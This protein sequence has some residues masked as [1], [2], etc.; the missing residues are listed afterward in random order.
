[1]LSDAALLV[2]ERLSEPQAYLSILGTLAGGFHAWSDIARLS[3]V[4]EGNLGYYLQ[5][6]QELEMVERRDPVLAP[7]GN[8]RGRYHI[9]DAFLRFHFRFIVPYRSSIERGETARVVKI[10]SE[11]LRAFIG[12]YVYEELCREWTL[13]EADAGRLGFLPEDVGAFWTQYRGKAVQLDVVAASQREKRLFIGEAKWEEEP[14]S[15]NIL[16]DLVQRSQR[17]PQVAEG[18]RAE[19]ALFSRGGFTDATRQAAKEIGARLID[20]PQMD[21]AL[22]KASRG[23]SATP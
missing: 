15:R 13:V 12:A 22:F 1:M 7:R 16:T 17:M 10:L 8:R 5:M 19:Y 23:E 21:R 20:L 14:L 6:L 18:W 3:G 2:H 4:P 9:S 11:D